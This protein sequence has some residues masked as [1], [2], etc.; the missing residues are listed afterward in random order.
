MRLHPYDLNSPARKA[1][2][3][4]KMGQSLVVPGNEFGLAQI[5]MLQKMVYSSE[6]WNGKAH[7]GML[8]KMVYSSEHWNGEDN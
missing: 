3:N 2:Q 1:E 6:H 7:I 4:L 8:Q 5:G